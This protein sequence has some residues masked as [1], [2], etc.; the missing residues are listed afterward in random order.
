MSVAIHVRD[1]VRRFGD[2][3]AVRDVA[4]YDELLANCKKMV[5]V[6]YQWSYHIV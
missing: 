6:V 2:F 4:L 5:N 3:V 1:L